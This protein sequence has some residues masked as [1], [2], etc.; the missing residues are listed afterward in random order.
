MSSSPITPEAA[1]EILQA[2]ALTTRCHNAFFRQKQLKSLHDALRNSSDAIRNAI[3]QDTH[4]S[5]EEAT[6]E[7]AIV[8]DLVKEHYA[9]INTTKE[10]EAEYR[11]TNGKDASDRRVPWGV[12]YIEPQKSHTPFFSVLSPLSA[13]VAAGTCVALKLENNLR[14]LPSLLRKLL[15]E[16]LESDTF[17]IIS[18]SPPA[19]SLSTCLQV[20][21]ETQVAQPTYSQHISPQGKVIAI[22]DRTADLATAA[23]H[24]V[25]ARFAFGGTS[26]YAPDIILVNEYIK[27]EFLEH[28]LQLSFRYLAGSGS[29]A[30]GVSPSN[31]ASN[32]KSSS[33]RISSAFSTLSSSKAW[34]LTTISQGDNGAIVELANLASLPPKFTQPILA[35]SPITSLEH[36]I[37]LV[38]QDLAPQ[39]SLL[40]S[41]HF[42]TNSTAKYLSQFVPAA[43]SFANG[44]PFS[45]LLGPAAPS[46]QAG[47]DVDKRYTI[48]H[49]LRLA[50]AYV[51]LPSNQKVLFKVLGGK[52]GGKA[53]S[54]MLSK[55][56]Q[57]IKEA[58]RK[59]SIA[60]G[61]FEQGILVGLGIYGIPLLTCIG[62]SLFFGVR[63]GLRKFAFI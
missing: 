8:L 31:N 9:S 59:E 16:A 49:F 63:A 13:A 45:L 14:T 42:G 10:L 35:V 37:S 27:K 62:A 26:P 18:S 44:V 32:Q 43:V 25:T 15:T 5:D 4:V 47:L 39:E 20:L 24:L 22:V 46:S 54:D 12:A 2:T 29:L 53:A 21:Q 36:A 30:N 11:I 41:Y 19:D 51:T 58:K 7:V 40:A 23:S 34:D 3:K 48:E 56:T 57:E 61:Y 50:P 17:L 55:A 1:L 6:T 28:V 33:S 60:I 52:E 38:E